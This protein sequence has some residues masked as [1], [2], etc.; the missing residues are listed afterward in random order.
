[1]KEPPYPPEPHEYVRDED[2]RPGDMVHV[3]GWK[4]ITAI[5][6]YDGPL[7]DITFALADTVPGVGFS[8]E[9]GGVTVRAKITSCQKL[10][11]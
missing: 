10:T 9:R 5:H 11:S 8:L 1:M 6:P 2:L 4:R 7:R 3:L